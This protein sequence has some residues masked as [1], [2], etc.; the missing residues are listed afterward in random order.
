M[1]KKSIFG[2]NGK[3]HHRIVHIRISL[4]TKFQLKLTIFIFQTQFAIVKNRKIWLLHVSMIVTYYIKVFRTETDRQNGF[5][6]SLHLIVAE[7]TKIFRLK[8]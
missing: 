3:N 1:P 2:R 5:L 7:T 8:K 4:D 6:M